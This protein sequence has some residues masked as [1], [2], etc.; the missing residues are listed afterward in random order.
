M[1][2]CRCLNTHLP[3]KAVTHTEECIRSLRRSTHQFLC[4]NSGAVPL[5][6]RSMHSPQCPCKLYLHWLSIMIRF[7]AKAC[8]LHLVLGLF[9]FDIVLLNF[10]LQLL[11][12][13]QLKLSGVFCLGLVSL[14]EN[15]AV[16]CL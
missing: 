12:R 3:R 10:Q 2:G 13:A 14:R 8:E 9:L 7:I 4:R 11:R 5:A 6:P 1:L 16:C 15:C